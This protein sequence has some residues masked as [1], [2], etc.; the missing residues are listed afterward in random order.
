[1]TSGASKGPQN[2]F[3]ARYCSPYFTAPI[4]YSMIRPLH[5]HTHTHAHRSTD[6]D[7]LFILTRLPLACVALF[8][9]D[10][11]LGNCDSHSFIHIRLIITNKNAALYNVVCTVE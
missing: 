4:N 9:F 2:I 1:V 6:A 7:D 5:T 11:G 3:Y 8:S 10:Y